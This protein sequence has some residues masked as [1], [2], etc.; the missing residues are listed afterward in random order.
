[1]AGC[2]RRIPALAAGVESGMDDVRLLNS[3]A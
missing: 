1:M 3:T 2:G